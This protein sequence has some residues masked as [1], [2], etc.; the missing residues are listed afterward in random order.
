MVKTI[1]IK[2]RKSLDL[3]EVPVDFNLVNFSRRTKTK[4]ESRAEMALVTPPAVHLKHLRLAARVNY[5]SSPNTAAIA[6]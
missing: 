4:V 6:T 3:A 5:H 1:D 2:I